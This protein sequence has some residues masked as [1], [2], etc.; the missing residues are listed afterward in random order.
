MKS[1]IY[2]YSDNWWVTLSVKGCLL[3]F[4]LMR[5]VQCSR[6]VLDPVKFALS[7]PTSVGGVK[8]SRALL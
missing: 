7:Q 5:T 4:G 8:A 2:S 3:T 1:F 6:A